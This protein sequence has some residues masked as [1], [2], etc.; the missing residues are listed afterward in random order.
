MLTIIPFSLW[1]I[2]ALLIVGYIA[3][4]IPGVVGIVIAAFLMRRF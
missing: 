3:F 4:G 1:A 2:L